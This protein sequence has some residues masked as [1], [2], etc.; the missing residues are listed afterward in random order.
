MSENLVILLE[1]F[2][3]NGISDF[4]NINPVNAFDTKKEIINKD[5]KPVTFEKTVDLLAKKQEEIKKILPNDYIQDIKNTCDSIQSIDDICSYVKQYD[6]YNNIRKL[7]NNTIIYD[8]S[9]KSDVLIINDFPNE[10]DDEEGTVFSGEAKEM[11]NNMLKAISLNS[12]DCC[13]L[14]SFFWRLAGN[15]I[16]IKEEFNLCK[17]VVEKFIKLVDPKIIIFMGNYSLNNLTTINSSLVKV[18]GQFFEYSNSYIFNKIESVATFG[19]NFLKNNVAKKREVWQDLI[20]IK[21]F[22]D[23]N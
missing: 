21:K 10:I 7:A 8:G 9:Q 5:I 3:A 20:N 1:W 22:L 14:N 12:D 11:M 2:R 6:G 16:P 17:P 4:F 13:F 19:P 15:R 23:N 18:R